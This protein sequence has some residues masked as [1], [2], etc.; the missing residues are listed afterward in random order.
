MGLHSTFMKQ[1][2]KK[3]WSNILFTIFIILLMIPQTR[4]PLQVA[5]NRLLS[6][7]PSEISESKRDH[8]QSYTWNLRNNLGQTK[9][10]EQA[11]GEVVV[12]NFWATWCAPCIAEMPS[13]QKVYN[14]YG[15]SVAFYFVSSEDAETLDSFL[16]KY[17]YDLP[18]YQPLT[19][20][21]DQLQ[22]R[23]LPTTFVISKSGELVIKKTGVA[24]WNA[25][26]FRSLLDELLLE[27]LS[28]K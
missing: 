7:S 28:F 20:T 17:H 12:L 22:D 8:L 14:E 19:R 15:D 26:S 25:K 4:M 24:D 27:D 11:K 21:P 6:F 16:A 10:F 3:H 13:F 18:V 5:L 2:L 23:S 1:I 9:S